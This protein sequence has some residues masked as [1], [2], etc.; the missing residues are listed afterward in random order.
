MHPGTPASN[1]AGFFSPRVRVSSRTG[2]ESCRVYIGFVVAS[3]MRNCRCVSPSQLSANNGKAIRSFGPTRRT[4]TIHL[5]RT[6]AWTNSAARSSPARSRTRQWPAACQ[7][8]RSKGGRSKLR[9]LHAAYPQAAKIS[10]AFIHN[11]SPQN[12]IAATASNATPISA[13]TSQREGL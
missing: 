5:P 7:T 2:C 1:G 9:K 10:S 11:A 6:V 13:M 8:T 12:A 4:S 3:R